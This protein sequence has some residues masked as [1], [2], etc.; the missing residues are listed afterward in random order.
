MLWDCG[1]LW[2]PIDCEGRPNKG[3]NIC[4]AAAPALQ[5]VVEEGYGGSRVRI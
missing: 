3:P 5:V 2:A 1:F 4:A